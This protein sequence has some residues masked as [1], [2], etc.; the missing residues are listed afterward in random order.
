MLSSS[1]Q[2]IIDDAPFLAMEYHKMTLGQRITKRLMD[3]IVAALVLLLFSPLYLIISACILLEDGKPVICALVC[4]W[5]G[6]LVS[7]YVP[8]FASVNIVFGVSEEPYRNDK[9]DSHKYIR[10]NSVPLLFANT[11]S[12]GSVEELEL[13]C[14]VKLEPPVISAP[15]PI[16]AEAAYKEPSVYR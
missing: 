12:P 15:S 3:I 13:A 7:A 5:L 2:I 8:I 4:V 10:A 11:K 14:N 9:F 1:R 6:K 16:V